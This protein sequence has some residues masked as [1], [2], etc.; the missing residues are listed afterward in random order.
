MRNQLIRAVSFFV[1]LNLSGCGNS[2]GLVRDFKIRT[3]T[4]TTVSCATAENPPVVVTG[5]VGNSRTFSV[6]L[7]A[8]AGK[9]VTCSV[10]DADSHVLGTF[11]YESTSEKGFGGQGQKLDTVSFSESKNVGVMSVF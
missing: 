9:G 3:K 7:S 5:S 2:K 1:L 4:A 8:V 10:L 11:L 6:D